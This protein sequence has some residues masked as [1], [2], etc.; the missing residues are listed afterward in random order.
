MCCWRWG[1]GPKTRS[2]VRFSLGPGNTADQV[3]SLIEAVIESV[4]HLRRISP[5]V[6][7]HA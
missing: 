3:D 2:S 1:K 7:A 4:A 5:A 6:V